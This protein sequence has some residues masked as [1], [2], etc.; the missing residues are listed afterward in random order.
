[1]IRPMV[2]DD[3]DEVVELAAVMYRESVNYRRLE[4]SPERVRE[5]VVMVMQNGFAVV[6]VKDGRIIGLMAGSLV[7]PAFSR[8][9]MACDF[10][11]YILPQHRGGTAAIRLVDAYVQWARQGGVKMITV[12]VT[13]GIDNDAAIAFYRAMGFRTSGVQMMMDCSATG[14]PVKP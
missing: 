5:M 12:G 4:F 8:D 1:M 2:E 7:Q 13:A 9:L 6:A 3:I 11:L 10:L 14:Q